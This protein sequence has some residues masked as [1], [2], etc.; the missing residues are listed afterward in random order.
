M[1][2][3]EVSVIDAATEDLFLGEALTVRQPRNGYRAGTDAVLLAA[4][5][6]PET[7]GKGPILDVGAGVG[8]VGLCVAARCPDA[9]VVLIEREA[10]LAMLARHNI[11]RNG[12]GMRVSVVETDIARPADALSRAGIASESFP[13]VLANPPYHHEGRG[14]AAPSPLKAV[15]HQMPENALEIWARFMTRMA[16]PGGR[17]A[18][19]H[20]AEALP[21]ILSVFEGRF[22]GVGILP[23][24]PRAGAAAI[25]VI[26]S[27]VKG[28]R[29]P[30]TIKPPLILHGPGQAFRPEVEAIFRH[31]AALPAQFGG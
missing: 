11:E 9:H 29:A 13:V 28:S 16:M 24:Y 22:G 20:K 26:V 30:I 27:G 14:T 17:V 15:S 4:L 21:Q 3:N 23:I 25:R 19:I 6:S 18:M 5:M 8:V 2:V 10:D 7:A 12:L 31:G 1:R